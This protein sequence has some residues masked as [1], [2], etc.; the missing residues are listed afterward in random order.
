MTYFQIIEPFLQKLNRL[1]QD[2]SLIKDFLCVASKNDEGYFVDINATNRYG[3]LKALQY[4]QL[5]SDESIIVE[6]FKAETERHRNEVFQG[7]FPALEVCGYLLSQY[8]KPNYVELFL[9]AK[10]ANFDTFCGFDRIYLISAG[11]KRTLNYVK[12]LDKERQDRFDELIGNDIKKIGFSEEK[13]QE[14]RK[15]EQRLFHEEINTTDSDILAILA[16]DLEILQ[17]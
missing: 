1:R 10:D 2:E 17:T 6:L 12:T 4:Q 5:P 11:V 16:E 14:W 8:K 15:N 7:L 9:K 3:I 13:L